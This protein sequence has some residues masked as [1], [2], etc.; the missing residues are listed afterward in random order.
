MKLT[1]ILSGLLLATLPA[2]PLPSWNGNPAKKAIIEFVGKVTTPGSPDYVD[3][4]ARIATFDND[5]CLWSEQP[6]YFQA[7]Y[8]FDRIKELA[9]DHPEWKDKE[10][11]AS[12][13]KDDIKGALAGGEKALLEMAMAT[14]AGLTDEEFRKA[15]RDWLDTARHPKTG[16][17]YDKMLYQPMLELLAYLRAE[18][19]KTF[20]VSGGGIDFVRVFAEEAY[21]I[22]PEQ[23]IG[24]SIKAGY[25]LRDGKPVVVKLPELNF[26]DDKAGKPVGIHQ[27]IGRR[28]IFAAGNSDGDF[29]ML[30]WTTAGEGARFGLLVHHDDAEREFA[31]DR[32]S[33]V[34]KLDRGLDEG[35]RRGWT[36]VS[37]KDDWARIYPQADD[38]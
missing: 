38:N 36:I 2:D 28:P 19:F 25:E 22:P 29:Q 15:V 21:G 33:H 8:I 35:P 27:H 23:V 24:S 34:G 1:L 7:F 4:A 20:I 9:P 18:G 17:A 26:I 30:E 11:F 6:M 12:V 37:M 5:G 31:Y 32:E 10:P 16:M 13:L 14:H 3:P